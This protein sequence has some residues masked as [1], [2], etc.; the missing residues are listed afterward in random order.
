MITVICHSCNL[1]VTGLDPEG[2][3][4]LIVIHCDCERLT[5]FDEDLATLASSLIVG[6]AEQVVGQSPVARL[7]VATTGR[8]SPNVACPRPDKTAQAGDRTSRLEP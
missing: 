5:T 3:A 2:A 6:E 4:L 7:P 8:G 1:T